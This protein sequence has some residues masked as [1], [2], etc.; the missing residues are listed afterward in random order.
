MRDV[1]GMRKDKK[2]KGKHRVAKGIKVRTRTGTMRGMRKYRDLQG[3]HKVD[4]G[5]SEESK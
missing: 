2:P 3:K 4:E 5:M 1:R